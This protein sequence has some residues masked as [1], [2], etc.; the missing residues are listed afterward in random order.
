MRVLV[1]GA[2]G[3]IGRALVAAL[4]RAGHRVVCA[5]RHPAPAG[6]ATAAQGEPLAVDFD[7][8]PDAAWWL[9]RLRG[10]DAVVNAVGILREQPGQTFEALHHRSPAALFDACARAGVAMVVQISALGADAAAQS[11]YHRTKKAAD[12]VLRGLPLRAAVV[13][14]SLVYGAGGASATMFN[15]MSALPLLALPRGGDMQVQPVHVDDVVAGVLALLDAPPAGQCT[16]AFVGPEP[17]QLREFL[18]QLRQGLAIGGTLRVVPLP[19]A[20]FRLG[21]S[22]AGR[23]PGSVLD[24][25]TAGM[26]LRGNVAPAEPFAQVL[27]RAPRPVSGFIDER[28]RAALRQEAMLGTWIPALRWSVA[29]LWLW[30]GIVSLGLYP[31]ADSLALLE[32]VG[33]RGV[34]G[35]LALYGAAGLDLVLGLA[36]VL[37]PAG[38][39]G[40]VWAA[41]LLLIAGYTVLITL[42]LP[43]YWLHPYGPITKNLPVLA[44]IAL[45]WAL[46]PA[47][48]SKGA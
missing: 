8:V 21:A 15:G 47:R 39:R 13:Q 16:I 20:L 31:V 32:R 11:R 26:L 29:L 24:S 4:L 18:Q 41:Q 45:L 27:G 12:D 34:A 7:A 19:E 40:V 5:S 25:E 30:T 3:F 37:A 48:P 17:L 33:L 9:P 23:I 10:I 38:R 6:A 35:Q 36:T 43:E 2:T 1:T 22:I 46:E 42:F 28:E 44:A 14:P